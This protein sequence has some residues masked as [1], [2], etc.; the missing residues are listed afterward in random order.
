LN[1]T[2]HDLVAEVLRHWPGK[3]IHQPDPTAPHEARRLNLAIDKAFRLLGW[4]PAWDFEKAVAETVAWY[5][6]AGSQTGTEL[7]KLTQKQIADYTRDAAIRRPCS[8]L[9]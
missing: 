1:I 4:R 7:L 8:V 5:R 9:K 2:V 6:A 3:S